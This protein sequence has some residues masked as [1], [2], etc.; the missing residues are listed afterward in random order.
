MSKAATALAPSYAHRAKSNN[1][2]L[3]HPKPLAKE[4]FSTEAM[5]MSGTAGGYQKA[6]ETGDARDNPTEHLR[7]DT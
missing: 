3:L 7:T 4:S 6:D 5:D 1:Q 2:G